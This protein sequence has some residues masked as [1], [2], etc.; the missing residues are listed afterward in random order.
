MPNQRTVKPIEGADSGVSIL[1][2]GSQQFDVRR[3]ALFGL[4][5]LALQET[6]PSACPPLQTILEVRTPGSAE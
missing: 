3:E 1:L 5:N 6:P 4:Y 2:A